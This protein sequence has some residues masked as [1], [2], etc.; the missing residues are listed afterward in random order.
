MAVMNAGRTVRVHLRRAAHARQPGAYPADKVA[1]QC[2]GLN[3]SV[4]ADGCGAAKLASLPT[5]RFVV[6]GALRQNGRRRRSV[7]LSAHRYAAGPTM[8]RRHER[9]RQG[10]PARCVLPSRARS[11][12]NQGQGFT[13]AMP[14]QDEKE[15]K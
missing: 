10:N 14:V 3:A 15:S 6:G 2:A 5:S 13:G 12:V 11:F 8:T 4:A 7:S 9:E 1:L